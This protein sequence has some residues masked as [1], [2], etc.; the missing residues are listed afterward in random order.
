LYLKGT[1]LFQFVDYHDDFHGIGIERF[2]PWSS[3]AAIIV[4]NNAS[5]TTAITTT[6]AGTSKLP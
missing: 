4:N 6:I 1:S 3:D 5:T 2:E